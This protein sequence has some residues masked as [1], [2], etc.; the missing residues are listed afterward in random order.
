MKIKDKYINEAIGYIVLHQ[1]ENKLK[2]LT[3]TDIKYLKSFFAS[4]YRNKQKQNDD[5]WKNGKSYYHIL[6]K[7]NI[8]SYASYIG[9]R[10]ASWCNINKKTGLFVIDSDD[11]GIDNPCIM[12]SNLYLENMTKNMYE[13]LEDKDQ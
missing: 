8:K 6:R 5:F 13:Q 1:H 4:L 9:N 11:Y 2:Q 7:S 12:I 10:W 3:N